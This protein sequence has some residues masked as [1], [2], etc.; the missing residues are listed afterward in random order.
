MRPGKE[1]K[2]GRLAT[3]PANDGSRQGA[4]SPLTGVKFAS[5]RLE[6]RV[7]PEAPISTL[8][9]F[10]ADDRGTDLATHSVVS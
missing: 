5:A 6:R 2:S 9:L 10:T 3:R 8:E 1:E 7:L 4:D